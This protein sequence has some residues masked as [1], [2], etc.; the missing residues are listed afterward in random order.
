MGEWVNAEAPVILARMYD[1]L[2]LVAVLAVLA[3]LCI[4]W[5][6]GGKRGDHR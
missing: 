5:V 6:L 1:L 4:Y 2:P 3:A